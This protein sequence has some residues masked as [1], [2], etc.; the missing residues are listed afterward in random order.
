MRTLSILERDPLPPLSPMTQRAAHF[1][2]WCCWL[3]LELR[4][5]AVKDT[6][7][8]LHKYCSQTPGSSALHAF[9]ADTLGQWQCPYQLQ[10]FFQLAMDH[11]HFNFYRN[12]EKKMGILIN[13]ERT[14]AHAKSCTL[15]APKEVSLTLQGREGASGSFHGDLL[16]SARHGVNALLTYL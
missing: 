3:C 12:D 16:A 5:T 11:Q 10:P 2:C 9:G 8:Q 6:R 15:L 7:K 1:H 4:D 14:G 13:Q